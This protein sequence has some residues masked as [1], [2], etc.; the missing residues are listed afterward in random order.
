MRPASV[1][2]GLTAWL[3]VIG[4]CLPPPLL[5]AATADR[6]PAVTDVALRDGGVLLG[7]VVDPQ[8]TPRSN[9]SVT[10]LSGQQHLG[11]A[12]TDKA[13]YFAFSGLHGGIYQITT[14]DGQ[15]AYRVWTSDAAPPS[16]QQGA[17]VVDGTD[18]VRGVRG[19][20]VRF[21][22]SNP[23]VIASI[24]GAL[25]GGATAGIIVATQPHS[26]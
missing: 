10:I 25:V 18:V 22:L 19:E 2:T 1:A 17:L 24:G 23:W 12:T 5:A 3:A 21:W 4:I 7:Q 6:T 8:G 16:A 15:G 20:Q 14:R 11:V 9:A 13:G 26:P